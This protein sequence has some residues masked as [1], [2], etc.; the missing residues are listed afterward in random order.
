MNELTLHPNVYQTGSSKG[1]VNLL[2]RMWVR[3][4][5]PGIGTIYIVSGF[6]NY[7]GGIRFYDIFRQHIDLGGKVVALFGGS[8]SQRLSSKQV[9]RELLA[10]G[11]EVHLVNRKRLMHAKSY[12]VDTGA[13]QMMVITSGN[14]TGPGMAQNVEISV[15][16]DKPTTATLGFSWD[17]MVKS[18]LSQAWDIHQPDLAEK[19]PSW[20]LLYD[21]AAAG[22]VLD[23]S[24]QMTMVMRLGHADTARIMANPGTDAYKGSQYFWLSKDAFGFFPALTILN[25]RGYK[26]TYSQKIEVAF[27]DLGVTQRVRVTFEADNNLDFRLG[28]GPLRGT[29]RA[30]NGDLVAITRR[31]ED[32]YEL[33]LYQQGT[34]LFSSLTPYALSFIGHQGKKFGYLTNS[35]FD[36]I[37][38]LK[39]PLRSGIH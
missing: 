19:M 22:I 35:D 38:G 6:A 4:H 3:E 23:E 39:P 33:R 20:Q 21:E 26:S 2:E 13:E 17:G 25:R 30:R 27:I 15:L 18:M 8:T 5:T 32:R 7:N 31:G 37:I 9:V 24:E 12:G 11:V 1:L 16:L 36:S 10:A 28:T 14:F 29:K 34:P